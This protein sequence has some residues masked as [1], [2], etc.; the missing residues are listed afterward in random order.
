MMDSS[1]EKL[2]SLAE[3]AGEGINNYLACSMYCSDRQTE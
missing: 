1:L 2:R 3:L